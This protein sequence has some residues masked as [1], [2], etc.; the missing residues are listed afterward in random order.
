MFKQNGQTREIACF[1][2]L[3]SRKAMEL[4]TKIGKKTDLGEKSGLELTKSSTGPSVS[5]SELEGFRKFLKSMCCN[6]ISQKYD[7][8][9]KGPDF[10]HILSSQLEAPQSVRISHQKHC[11]FDIFAISQSRARG[12]MP[13]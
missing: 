2:V 5:S 4:G 1:A 3:S 7:V 11:V 8:F 6:C 10:E 9:Q 12:K 13:F